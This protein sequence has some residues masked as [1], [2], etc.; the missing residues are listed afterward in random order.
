V[1]GCEEK[2]REDESEVEIW[3]RSSSCRSRTMTS[4]TDQSVEGDFLKRMISPCIK[5]STAK[6]RS[7]GSASESKF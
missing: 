5:T 7:S 3:K 4:C 1:V 6:G 2:R